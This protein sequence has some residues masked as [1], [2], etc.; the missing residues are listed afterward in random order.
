MTATLEGVVADMPEE[1]YHAHPALSVSG[2]K[3]LL[4]P[5][6]P[7]IFKHE[8]DNG[9]PPKRAF[10]I[11]HAAHSLVLGVGAEIVVVDATDWRTKAAKE[12]AEAARAEGKTP[13]L[14]EDYATVQA[15]AARLR[16]HPKAS[17]LFDPDHGR[18]EVSLFWEDWAHG[19]TRRSRLDWLPDTDGGRVTVVD[20]KTTTAVDPESLRKTIASFGYAQQDSW[21]REAVQACGIA[22]DV[23][24]R[25]VFQAKTAPY[26]VAVVELDATA[27][28][29]GQARNEQA[30][31]IFADCTASGL[32]PGYS[33]DVQVIGLPTWALPPEER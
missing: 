9:Q 33:D 21:Y 2:A 30:L 29:V 24:F 5:S 1:A 17:A 7:A 20:Y 16:E 32:W 19:V 13:L 12:A 28:R 23:G 27:R 10:D 4:P 6:C 3:K 11:G 8:R 14:P 26:L 31:R 22:E 15:M 18:P 25:F